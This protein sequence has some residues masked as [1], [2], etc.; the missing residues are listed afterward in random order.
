MDE[1]DNL[2]QVSKPFI[3]SVVRCVGL[4]QGKRNKDYINY[5]ESKIFDGFKQLDI[6]STGAKMWAS[7]ATFN[8]NGMSFGSNTMS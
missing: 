7:R 2:V 4:L 3:N 6:A 1:F 8:N 5:I